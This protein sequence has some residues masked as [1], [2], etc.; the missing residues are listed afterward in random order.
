MIIILH[1][2]CLS[3]I[4]N[5]QNKIVIQ[6]GASKVF[7]FEFDKRKIETRKK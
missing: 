5:L 7:F 3:F 4:Q 6:I 1:K 2:G